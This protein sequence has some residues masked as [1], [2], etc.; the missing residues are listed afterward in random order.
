MPT[1]ATVQVGYRKL[2]NGTCFPYQV[3]RVAGYACYIECLSLLWDANASSK[4]QDCDCWIESC[5]N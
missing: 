5:H 1:K 2:S 4:G 3:L